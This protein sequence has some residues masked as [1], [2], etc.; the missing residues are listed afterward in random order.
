[1][2]GPRLLLIGGGHAHVFVFEALAR[3]RMPVG[4]VTLVSPH[5]HQVYSGMVPGLIAGRYTLDE[6]TFDLPAIA[7]RCGIRFVRDT[8]V[9]LDPAAR[10]VALA[11]GEVL[12]Y[13]VVSFAIGGAPAGSDRPGVA[14]YAHFVKPINR[15]LE[16]L[17]AIDHAAATRGPE[18]LQVVVAGAGA[19]GV[20]VALALRA[21]LDRLDATRAVITLYDPAHTLL[22]D[23]HPAARRHAER[24]LRLGE[25]T[26]RLGTGIEEVG[27]SYARLSGGRVVP[28]DLVVWTAGT[29]APDLFRDSGLP[30]DP[31]GFLLVEETLQASGVPEVFA[32]GD[33]ASLVT[34]PQTPK[35]G[36]YAVRQAP[37][38][39][40]NLSAAL[41]RVARGRPPGGAGNE[42]RAYHPQSRFLALLNTGDGRAIFSY[43]DLALAGRWAMHLKDWI[44]RG[45]MRRF[46]RLYDTGRHRSRETGAA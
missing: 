14:E 41:G 32:A 45:F 26:L 4:E 29:R 19:A 18:P 22:R 6:V 31:H 44:D 9:R 5:D 37:V 21:R 36:V 17:P 11:S 27:A 28:A 34:A 46:Q 7:A 16:L 42:L 39:V 40:H 2:G 3:G 1:M 24:A 35:A 38:L 8:A 25:I 23:R 20:E 10:T 43:G 30:T 15:V 13:D 33:A 12:A